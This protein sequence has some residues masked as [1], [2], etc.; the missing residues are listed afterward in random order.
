MSK[1]SNREF[2]VADSACTTLID[3]VYKI[4]NSIEVQLDHK[5]DSN[6]LS[7]KQ[8]AVLQMVADNERV[9][10][11]MVVKNTKIPFSELSRILDGLEIKGYMKRKGYCNNDRRK[12]ELGIL[13]K[14][15]ALVET[16]RDI[17]TT[18]PQ[19]LTSLLT[20]EEKAMLS[21]FLRTFPGES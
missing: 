15:E 1:R 17:L 14:G 8:L 12:L 4:H 13:P 20:V 11:S 2:N 16:S 19:S 18:L 9:N 3:L 5:L 7:R 6:D 21:K 10:P